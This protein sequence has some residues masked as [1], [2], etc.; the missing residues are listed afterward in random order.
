[1]DEKQAYDHDAPPPTWQ[2][3]GCFG[4]GPA[5]P[6][7]LHL[8]FALGPDGQSYICEFEVGS[9]FIGPPGHVHGGIIA[10]ILDEAM[11]KANKLKAKVALTRR[12]EVN[13]FR[14]VPIGEPLIVEGRNVGMTGRSI[15]N[16]AE[17]RTADGAVLARSTGEFIVIDADKMFARELERER[18]KSE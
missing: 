8:K 12:M 17:L 11:G 15:Y 13:Y 1:M 3:D 10:T 5:N 4:C 14:P 2:R 9:S 18:L 7:G 16:S 6:S